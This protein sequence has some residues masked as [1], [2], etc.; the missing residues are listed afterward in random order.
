MF[1]SGKSNTNSSP[2]LC[3]IFG[4]IPN[5]IQTE[6]GLTWQYYPLDC[7]NRKAEMS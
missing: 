4:I 6:N 3:Y 1:L 7:V 2:K 5:E